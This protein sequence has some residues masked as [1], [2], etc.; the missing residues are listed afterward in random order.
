MADYGLGLK[1]LAIDE[2][3][4]VIRGTHTI[5]YPSDSAINV[6]GP[7]MHFGTILVHRVPEVVSV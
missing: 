1:V 6:R 4:Q 2:K 5:L 3:G 7:I